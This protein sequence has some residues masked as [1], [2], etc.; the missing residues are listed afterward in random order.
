MNLRSRASRF[1]GRSL[2]ENTVR[3]TKVE[4]AVFHDVRKRASK[5]DEA[6][7]T[8]PQLPNGDTLD[9]RVWEKLAED[10]FYEFFGEDAPSVY[11]RDKVDPRFHVNREITGKQAR[12]ES[13]QEQHAMTRGQL[14][15]STLGTLGTLGA[16]SRSYGDE[17]AEHAEAQ[18]EIAEA[19]DVIES[20]DDMLEQL[21]QQRA[22][23]TDER[24]VAELDERTRKEAEA[25]RFAKDKLA[26]AQAK[27][28]QQGGALH[29]AVATAVAKAVQEGAEGV[30]AASL[31]P[32]KGAGRGKRVSPDQILELADRVRVSPVMR[33]VLEM[34][35]RMELSMGTVRRQMRKGGFEEMVDIETG[36]DLRLVLTHEKA[37]LSHPVARYDFYRRFAERSL[38]QY[39][40]WSEQ[41]LKRGPIIF[42]ADGSDSMRGAP[43]IF[44]RGLTLA[45]CSIGNRE[46]R[47]TAA[48]EF[49][50]R[51][52]LRTFF[53]PKEHALDPT[54]ALDF[55]EHFFAGG[56]DINSALAQAE[57]IINNEAPFH[58]ADLVIVTDG[59]DFLTDESI[60]TRDRLRALGV[61]IHGIAVGI[62]P[63]QY[64]VEICDRVS[65][66]FDY[67]GPNDTSDRL[68]IDI[69]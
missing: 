39:E 45:G 18:N 22:E 24:L 33:A 16:L 17:L 53:F 65:S 67:A 59:G 21:R 46:G 20:I 12:D 32:G 50:S 56:T 25:K 3:H 23:A 15:E 36:D 26:G 9:G 68:A 2:E 13:F 40:M 44:C 30:E 63:T 42:A 31:I 5:L 28:A 35:G 49:G 4:R 11:A 48:I 66:V 41:E 47:N 52:Q 60:A 61:K 62:T 7:R 64:L 43:N 58:S 8:P 19:Q 38:M 69:S 57:D 14:M 55:A 10:V 6:V 1:F 27:Q 51:G 54:T 37:L 34:M 29:D